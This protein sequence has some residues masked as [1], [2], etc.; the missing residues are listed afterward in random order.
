MTDSF[1]AQIGL[2]LKLNSERSV[3]PVELYLS[4]F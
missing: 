2:D 4:R 3:C 1:S